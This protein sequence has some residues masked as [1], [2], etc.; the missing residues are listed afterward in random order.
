MSD[1]VTGMNDG[2]CVLTSIANYCKLDYNLVRGFALACGA[3]TPSVG[4]QTKYLDKILKNFGW[5]SVETRTYDIP[6]N[7][8]LSYKNKG[9]E[10]HHMVAVINGYI[11]SNG[12]IV[13]SAK[14]YLKSTHH[15]RVFLLIDCREW[16]TRLGVSAT[17]SIYQEKTV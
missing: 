5:R 10:T 14:Q 7:C 16:L 4:T 15:R 6:L 9:S 11:V 1:Y 2:D 13:G 3:F 8:L 17:H 12:I